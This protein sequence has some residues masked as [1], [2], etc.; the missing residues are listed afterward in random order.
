MK[1]FEFFFIIFLFFQV[2]SAYSDTGIKRRL[3]SERVDPQVSRKEG[4]AIHSFVYLNF[5]PDP[6]SAFKSVKW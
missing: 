2:R 4:S 1:K 6:A 3:T 5:S